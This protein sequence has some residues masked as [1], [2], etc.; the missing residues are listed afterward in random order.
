MLKISR[1]GSEGGSSD[2]DELKS[3]HSLAGEGIDLGVN[4]V[5]ASMIRQGNAFDDMTGRGGEHSSTMEGFRF[6]I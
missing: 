5:H 6:S 3:R 2:L 1:K 4:I